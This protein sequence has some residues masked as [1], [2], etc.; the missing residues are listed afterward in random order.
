MKNHNMWSV[1]C[2]IDITDK[3]QPS[4][5][6]LAVHAV[7]DT[8]FGTLIATTHLIRHP[9]DVTARSKNSRQ[10]RGKY[11]VQE[12][13]MADWLRSVLYWWGFW[14]LKRYLLLTGY[15]IEWLTKLINMT[16]GLSYEKLHFLSLAGW[17]GGVVA[18]AFVWHLKG[19]NK[20]TKR[21][22]C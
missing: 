14:Y 12:R 9:V 6:W 22:S 17:C 15:P 11:P 20:T 18:A 7:S 4:I 16:F 13:C 8:H 3:P 2:L 21:Y 19:K 1:T 5:K 10:T